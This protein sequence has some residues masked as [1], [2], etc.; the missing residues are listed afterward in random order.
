MIHIPKRYTATLKDILKS[1]T[2]L[3]NRKIVC[4]WKEKTANKFTFQYS[5]IQ[6]L[7]RGKLCGLVRKLYSF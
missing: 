3:F 1:K 6:P 2:I 7:S 4:V 5:N